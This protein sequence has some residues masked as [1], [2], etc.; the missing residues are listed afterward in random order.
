[1]VRV[2]RGS[3]GLDKQQCT[4]QLTIFADGLPCVKPLVIFRGTVKQITVLEKLRYDKCVSVYFQI[5]TWC[6][7][8]IMTQWVRCHWKPHV[9][10]PTMV[11]LDQIT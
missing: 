11:L 7:E 6:D 5:N 2:Q 10:D 9:E 3:S 8:Q 1:M 4:V